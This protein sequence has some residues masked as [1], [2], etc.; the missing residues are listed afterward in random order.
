MDKRGCLL[1][2]VQCQEGW[3]NP[4]TGGNVPHPSTVQ[5]DYNGISKFVF[6]EKIRN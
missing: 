1:Q 6:G 2:K 4:E 5:T 3:T